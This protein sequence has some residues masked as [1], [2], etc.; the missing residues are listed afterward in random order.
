MKKKGTKKQAPKSIIKPALKVAGSV[1]KSLN[2]AP[3]FKK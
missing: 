3:K 1:K 2:N